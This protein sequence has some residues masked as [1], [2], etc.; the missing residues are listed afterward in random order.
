MAVIIIAQR[1]YQRS[2]SASVLIQ[3]VAADNAAQ[4]A[5]DPESLASK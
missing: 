2:W 4:T 1:D 5:L 3:P